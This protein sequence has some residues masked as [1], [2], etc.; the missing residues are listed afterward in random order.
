MKTYK[1]VHSF[2][3]N[4]KNSIYTLINHYSK[5]YFFYYLFLY[6]KH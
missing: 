5:I 6:E 1:K 3:I 2:R 4:C